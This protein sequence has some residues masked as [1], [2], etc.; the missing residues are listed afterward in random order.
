MSSD[1]SSSNSAPQTAEPAGKPWS[2]PG[3]VAGCL[4]LLALLIWFMAPAPARFMPAPLR[5]VPT[6][7]PPSPPDFVPTDMTEIP[8]LDSSSLSIAQQNH[9]LFR[10]NMEPCPCGCNSSIAACRIG[11][12]N[13]PLIK[14]L[15]GKISAEE[16]RVGGREPEVGSQ[17]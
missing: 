11:H 4:I 12:P 6:G 2:S 1:E 10:L 14:D 8:G 16:L 5:P 13:C 15:L 7:C 3:L 17:K 9:V